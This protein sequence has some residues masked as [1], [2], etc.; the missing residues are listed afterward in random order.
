MISYTVEKPVSPLAPVVSRYRRP[1][2]FFFL[3]TAIPWVLWFTA[4]AISRQPQVTSAGWVAILVLALA[5]LSAPM[6]VAAALVRRDPALLR[7]VL[8]RLGNVREV[9]WW[10][11][12]LAVTLLPGA[13]VL[14]TAVS[15][16]LGYPAEQFLPREGFSFTSGLAPAWLTLGLAA[17]LEELGWKTYGTDA[18]AS[19]W[20]VWRTS[21]VFGV[22]W[23]LWHVPLASIQGMYQ[24]EVVETGLLASLNFGLSIFPFVILMNWLYYR[25][26]RNI[27]VPIVF[28]LAANFGNELLATHP[29]TKAIKTAILLVVSGIVV[30]RER[31]LFFTR[32]ARS[33]A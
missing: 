23:F 21:L 10:A 5:G 8:H 31:E 33:L 4:G 25:S 3:A 16:P 32:P 27:L 15:I 2:L 29:D 9:P 28:H 1:F 22:V 7:D 12:L 14:G 17:V 19:R 26:G 18:L 30:W 11:W 24:A 13:L 6:A 20:T